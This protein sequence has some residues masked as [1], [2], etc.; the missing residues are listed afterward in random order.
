[1]CG[2]TESC[3]SSSNGHQKADDVIG[4]NAKAIQI[5]RELITYPRL[6][7]HEAKQLGLKVLFFLTL[8]F[9]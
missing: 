6:F 3:T 8:H 4:G 9:F 1:M 7:T 2:E 5:L